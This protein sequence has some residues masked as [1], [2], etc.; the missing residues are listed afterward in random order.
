MKKYMVRWMVMGA[1]LLGSPFVAAQTCNSSVS[2]SAPDSRY[3]DHGDGSV[4]DNRTGL[5]WRQCSEGLT[6]TTTPCDT[7]AAATYDW[8]GAHQRALDVNGNGAENLGYSDWRLPN[9]NELASL[10]ESQCYSPSIN[11][12]LFPNTVSTIYWSASP[13]ALGSFDAWGVLFDYGSVY[14]YGKYDA[15]Y[16]RLVRGGQ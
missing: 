11:A 14:Y 1:W 12:T 9:R 4:T 16:V 5:M 10:V 3:V 15:V 13:D 2:A 6:T 8:S 7:G